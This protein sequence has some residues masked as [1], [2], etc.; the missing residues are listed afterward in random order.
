MPTIPELIGAAVVTCLGMMAVLLGM[1][2]MRLGSAVRAGVRRLARLRVPRALRELE[3]GTCDGLSA[4]RI[5]RMVDEAW[6]LNRPSR[7]D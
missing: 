4:E 6:F 7:R 3:H 1:C 2:L 5:R